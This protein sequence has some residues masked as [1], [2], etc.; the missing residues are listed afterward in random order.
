MKQLFMI[1]IKVIITSYFFR[2]ISLIVITTFSVLTKYYQKLQLWKMYRKDFFSSWTICMVSSVFTLRKFY[3][4][5]QNGKIIIGKKW[6]N[7]FHRCCCYPLLVDF[8]FVVWK[9]M[10][11]LV[12][13]WKT[14]LWTVF[15][16]FSKQVVISFKFYHCLI[17]NSTITIIYFFNLGYILS[18]LTKQSPKHFI[19]KIFHF[20][21][22][23]YWRERI[24]EVC[25]AFYGVLLIAPIL[26]LIY[27][28]F[29]SR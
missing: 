12:K 5:K 24:C 17:M 29:C 1:V 11:Q 9:K 6:L 18:A 14:A 2:I 15:I 16:G 10:A 28:L 4:E 27:F 19:E 23:N 7:W 25:D 26:V 8:M 20:C 13:F 22:S 3:I 21:T